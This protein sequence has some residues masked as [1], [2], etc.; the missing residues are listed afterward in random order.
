M[1]HIVFEYSNDLDSKVKE[2]GSIKIAHETVT[3]SGL[4]NP[5]A[6][7]ARS[8]SYADYVL[9][10]GAKNFL[11]ITVSILTGRDEQE[12]KSLSQSVFDAVKNAIP[13]VDKL[14]VNIHEMDADSYT[15]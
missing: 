15:K 12:R 1:P 4:F 13:D 14:S 7:K 2:S 8:V 5:E 6:V 3:A 10:P 9:P 11:H